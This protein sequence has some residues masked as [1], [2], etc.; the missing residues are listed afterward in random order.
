MIS[1]KVDKKLAKA[2]ILFEAPLEGYTPDDIRQ[3]L[4]ERHKTDVAVAEAMASVG[5]KVGWL[6]HE[7]NDPDNN[8]ATIAKYEEEY[9]GWWSLEKEL[10][11]EIILRLEKQNAKQGTSY[12]TTGNGWHYIIE[13]FMNQNGYRDGAGWWIKEMEE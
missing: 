6:H 12:R 11:A 5:Q 3:W 1:M 2:A 9:D 4:E 8:E 7:I 13:P 10:V